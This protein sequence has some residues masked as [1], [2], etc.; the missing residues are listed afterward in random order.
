[1]VVGFSEILKDS[2]RA[3]DISKTRNNRASD[4]LCALKITS[5]FTT[6]NNLLSFCCW[7]LLW[8]F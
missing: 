7:L 5:A 6:G 4:A 2:P 3:S 8:W 1:M